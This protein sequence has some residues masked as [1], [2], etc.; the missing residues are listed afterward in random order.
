MKKLDLRILQ[1]DLGRQK[2]TVEYIKSY[3]DFAKENG[4]NSVLL[5]LEAAVK[6]ACVP[7]F[8]DDDTYTPDEM[9]E[10]VAYG[11][12]QGI[13]IIPALEDLAHVE[14]FLRYE[15][16]A[17]LSEC[18]DAMVDGRGIVSGLGHC[19]CPSNPEGMAF[20]D[21][22]YRQVIELF[23]SPYVHVGMDEPFDFAVCPRCAARI[24][25]GETKDDIFC[26][27][28]MRVY[29]LV[30]SFGRTMMMWDDF[31]EY[32]D[33]AERMPRDIIMCNWNYGFIG[34]EP[35][36]HWMNRKKRD[37]FRYYDQLGFRYLFCTYANSSSKLYNTD[38]FTAYASKYHPAG[39]LMTVWERNT[40]F[41]LCSYPAIAYTGRFWSGKATEEDKLKIYTDFLGSKEAA[42]IVLNLETVGGS[43][44][45]NNANI[46]E[47]TT[48]ATDC[49]TRTMGYALPRLRKI[50]DEMDDCQAKDILQDIYG[51]MLGSYLARVK[52]NICL[53]IFDNY[54]SRSK[55]PA[56][57]AKKF[58][59]LKEM[60]RYAHQ[61]TLRLW[62][63]Y[64]PGIKPSGGKFGDGSSKL[65]RQFESREKSYDAL[66]AELEKGEKHGVFYAELMLHC[67]YGTP[68]LIIELHYK[69]K[70]VAPTVYKTGAKVSGAVNTV[71]FAMENKALDY[72]VFTVYG[73]GAVY[74]VHF[75]YTCKGKKYVVSGVTKLSGK[76]SNLKNILLNDTQFAE[77][78]NN[79][80][81]AHFENVELCREKHSIKLKF[82]PMK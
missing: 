74:P 70:S 69:D 3:I 80:G 48:A 35:Q 77:L 62:E 34:D 79:D 4:Y 24:A 60:N 82:K 46:C 37:W 52:H 28:L 39:A 50:A 16:L 38:T 36:G 9:R 68:K 71:R 81:Q 42:D 32:L 75:R 30:K 61:N 44:Y 54:E 53:E 15:E 67:I 21:T 58:L 22:Y 57:F 76:G 19:A 49:A 41:Y 66:I 65:D 7:F 63:K 72:A 11:N 56:Y 31:F 2:E 17:F 64:R 47:N 14:N 33:I 51:F 6:V 45:P 5:Y 8:S 29:D 27:H 18:K 23:T 78:G 12:T 73:E 20:L 13:D 40:K 25:K 1:I 59:P 10:I 26:A 43:T 55:S